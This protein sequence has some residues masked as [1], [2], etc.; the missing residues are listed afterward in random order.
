MN[1]IGPGNAGGGGGSG[2]EGAIAASG[3]QILYA[4]VVRPPWLAWDGAAYCGAQL[5]HI[6]ETSLAELAAMTGIVRVFTQRNFVAVVAYS[7]AQAAIGARRLRVHWS[8][9]K[10]PPARQ[11]G[12]RTPAP[13]TSAILFE[14][15]DVDAAF[16]NADTPIERAYAWPSVPAPSAPVST[17]ALAW[18][19]GHELTVWMP[20]PAAS[21]PQHALRTELAA[22]LN[23]PPGAI[24]L[25]GADNTNDTA[26]DAALLSHIMRQPVQ[27]TSPA[28]DRQ[29]NVA[30]EDADRTLY[31][32]SRIDGAFDTDKKL[33]GYRYSSGPSPQA[34]P[35]LAL[36]LTGVA[37]AID[38][39]AAPPAGQGAMPPYAYPNIRIA[40]DRHCAAANASPAPPA[41]LAAIEKARIDAAVFAHESFATEAALQAGIDPVAFRLRHLADG[42]G[43]QLIASVAQQ[44]DWR[45]QSS[46]AA[47]KAAS[48]GLMRG[49]GFAYAHVIENQAGKT[50][51]SWSAWI[52]DVA[53]DRDS[54]DISVSRVIVGQDAAQSD[55]AGDAGRASGLTIT[56]QLE[57]EAIDAARLLLQNAPAFD[58]WG[59]DI[60]EPAPARTPSIAPQLTG[61]DLPIRQRAGAELGPGGAQLAGGAAFSLPAAAALAN[62]IYDATGVRLR[63]PPFSGE[64]IRLGLAENAGATVKP[65]KKWLAAG[66]AVATALIGIVTLAL[67]WRA[68][69]APVAPPDP[70]LYS[71]AAITRGKLVAA[72]GD[73][74]V[75]HTAPDG[76]KN[77]GGLALDTPFG[78]IYSTN[79]TPDVETGI[80]NWSYAAFE[81]AM[82]EGIRRDGKHLYPAFPYTAFAKTSDADLQA[83]Y[84]YLMAQ[85]PVKAD[86]PKTKLAFPFNVRPLMA[87]WNLLF[88]NPDAYRPDPSRSAEWNRG[89]YLAEGLGHCGACHTPR[90]A[91]GAEK[92]LRAYLSGG[93][94]EGWEAPA[95]TS[96]SKAPIPWTE[97]DLFDYLRTGFSPLHGV[98][99]GPMGP[100]VAEMA[101]M[102]ESDVKAIAHYIASFGKPA[103]EAVPAVQAAQALP[104]TQDL[105]PAQAAL[106]ARI[107]QNNAASART[108]SGNGKNIYEGACAVCHQADLGPALFGVK[109][110]LALNTNLYSATPDNLVRVILN[111]INTP[112]H[113]ELGYMPGFRDSFD[114]SQVDDLVS[115]LRGRFAAN[116]PAWKNISETS[117]KLRA[118]PAH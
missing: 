118:E 93:M 46:A 72:A 37:V 57:G 64:R 17:W 12:D 15:G 44:G 62:A 50:V 11:S 105:Q 106:A 86:P 21:H 38:D 28:P 110:S 81:R 5:L 58:T 30:G 107:E 112:A 114:D 94:A 95:L 70:A 67:P 45:P 10:S 39:I 109:P 3:E 73:C 33:T 69:I 59:S 92:G 49:R 36:L 116:Q 43:A 84:A 79:I 75:C 102:P 8:L 111:G 115:Y 40:E 98:A 87:G 7:D 63:E 24:T 51:Q 20:R 6:D 32:V 101:Q 52:A 54:G 66:A 25:I 14:R 55:S 85:E 35:A 96:L 91:M 108:L 74:V 26:A 19:G 42:R 23:I 56:R 31:L 97:T 78:T 53:Y 18:H 71:A 2:G 13:K 82:R 83:L 117:A 22:L 104:A 80:G 100:V 61:A 47:A 4:R 29:G 99:A 16:E 68:P 103:A 60:A 27:V 89:A 9:P 113:Q 1:E 65:Y 88:H 34:A 77:A 76:I 48:D 90:N 41:S